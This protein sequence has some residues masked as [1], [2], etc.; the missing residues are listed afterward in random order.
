MPDLDNNFAFD[1]AESTR[2]LKV[3]PL[4]LRYPDDEV[5]TDERIELDDAWLAD[6]ELVR[7]TRTRAGT[8]TVK[9][10]DADFSLAERMGYSM[11]QADKHAAPA[12]SAPPASA[13]AP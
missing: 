11:K 4:F 8:C 5:D 3:K 2:R 6:A 1:V 7:I 12:T 13:P 10:E 9:M